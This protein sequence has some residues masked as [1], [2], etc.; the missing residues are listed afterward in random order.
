MC[1]VSYVGDYWKRDFPDRHPG[2]YEPYNPLN[3]YKTLPDITPPPQVTK[4]EFDALKKEMEELKK[5]L[6]AAK[7]FDEATGQ[8][9]CE[10]DE[11]VALIKQVAKHVG[12]D[13]NEVFGK[14]DDNVGC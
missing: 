14:D 9:D 7:K 8:P 12:V 11:K 4:K 2:W 3:P 1:A 5:M 10:M 6:L 13:M